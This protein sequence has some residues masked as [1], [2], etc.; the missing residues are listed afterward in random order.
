MPRNPAET[1]YI[2]MF[3]YG[4]V[5]GGLAGGLTFAVLP[6]TTTIDLLIGRFIFGL[7]FGFCFGGF[8]GLV[9]GLAML[10]ITVFLLPKQRTE[11]VIRAYRLLTGTITASITS[12]IF[13]P[14]WI[15]SWFMLAQEE[16]NIFIGLVMSVGIAVYVSQRTVTK[17][18]REMDVRKKKV[19][20]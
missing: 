18:L 2:R 17:Y 6:N 15:A 9:N 5:L 10:M 7:I 20:E 14:L 12:L 19:G 8:A 11:K 4:V 3:L 1:I 16:P 13:I